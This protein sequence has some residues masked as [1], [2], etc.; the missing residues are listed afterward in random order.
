MATTADTTTT[1]QE[2]PGGQHA[3][4]QAVHGVRYQVRDV[5]RSV[6]FYTTH[7]GF[8]L[9]HQQLP[10]FA[11]VSLGDAQILLSGPL[12]SGS[13]PMPNGQRQEPGGW[14]R[15]V[16]RVNRCVEEGRPSFSERDGDG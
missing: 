2:K 10:A 14:N 5:A 4:V 9:E 3:S 15:V 1:A 13:R 7:L 8:T 6:A 12:A 11:S 16:L